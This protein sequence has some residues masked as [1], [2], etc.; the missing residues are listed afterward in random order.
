MLSLSHRIRLRAFAGLVGLCCGI[1]FAERLPAQETAFTKPGGPTAAPETLPG[2][3]FARLGM[4][5]AVVT[6]RIRAATFSPDGRWLAVIRQNRS[7][8]QSQIAL[9]DAKSLAQVRTIAPIDYIHPVLRFSHDSETLHETQRSWSVHTGEEVARPIKGQLAAV[10][11]NGKF[12]VVDRGDG[13]HIVWDVANQAEIATLE[14]RV[15][16]RGTSTAISDDGKYVAR[17]QNFKIRFDDVSK[18]TALEATEFQIGGGTQIVAIPGG[19]KFVAYTHNFGR[20]ALFDP[21][22]GKTVREFPGQRGKQAWQVAV[23]TDGR[24]VA[25]T[26]SPEIVR[27][28]EVETGNIIK[29]LKTPEYEF[30]AVA[31]SADNKTLLAAGERVNRDS[32]FFVWDTTNWQ[33]ASTQSELTGPLRRLVFSP[34]GRW[35]AADSAQG[36]IHLWDVAGRQLART[37]AA[38]A[39]FD[40]RFS[41]DGWLLGAAGREHRYG[42][43]EVETGDRLFGAAT[44]MPPYAN[45]GASLS[46]ELDW[47]VVNRRDGLRRHKTT[48][49]EP[50]DPATDDNVTLAGNLL[51]LSHSPDGKFLTITSDQPLSAET[52]P[53]ARVKVATGEVTYPFKAY[54][55]PPNPNNPLPR[56]TRFQ[57]ALWSPDGATFAAADE[58]RMINLWD[59]RSG[60]YWDVLPHGDIAAAFSLDG[61]FVAGFGQHTLSLYEVA[62]GEEVFSRPLRPPPTSPGAGRTSQI[63]PADGL[64]E[65]GLTALAIS[66]D[67]RLLAG[68]FRDDDSILLWNLV[69]LDQRQIAELRLAG[70]EAYERWWADLRGDDPQ[71]A[72][73]AMWRFALAGDNAIAFLIGH[74]GRR[75]DKANDLD[76]IIKLLRELDSNDASARDAA[77]KSLRGVSD[78][79]WKSVEQTLTEVSWASNRIKEDSQTV[80]SYLTLEQLARL[81]AIA[82]LERNGSAAAVGTLQAMARGPEDQRATWLA[83]SAVERL[84]TRGGK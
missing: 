4:P 62:S 66:P 65:N 5:H 75:A 20:F 2:G 51:S 11:P 31:Y 68:A 40:L 84:K 33:E 81:R 77:A 25:A 13:R 15:D 21:A 17:F 47:L 60:A 49:G 52:V 76:N 7:G 54:Q 16:T 70:A 80:S 42:V 35:L 19:N 38:D 29:D 46:P 39:S 34:D 82:A 44:N 73:T 57:R 43:W 61:N 74:L 30:R 24:Q 6:G 18:G 10:S 50:V 8:G 1:L 48:N 78:S 69:P 26:L 55:T 3:A 22:T 14:S 27:V 45:S 23:S 32:R 41:P 12:W 72:Y 67:G 56:G 63:V 36:R 58:R 28:W 83:A 37:I 9:F 53:I 79:R 59:V 64:P 71:A